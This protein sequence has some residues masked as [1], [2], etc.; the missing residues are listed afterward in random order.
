MT[1]KTLKKKVQEEEKKRKSL[2]DNCENTCDPQTRNMKFTVH[3]CPDFR[4]KPTGLSDLS[5]KTNG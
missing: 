4:R 5:N 2:C 1:L 3:N